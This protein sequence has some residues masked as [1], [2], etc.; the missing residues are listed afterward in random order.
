MRVRFRTSVIR[1]LI[2]TLAP[3]FVF[4]FDTQNEVPESRSHRHSEKALPAKKT[5]VAGAHVWIGI[6]RQRETEAG[7]RGSVRA[8]VSVALGGERLSQSKRDRC[9]QW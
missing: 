6:Q 7:T 1:T 2:L 8:R 4:S 9:A 3:T 5:D